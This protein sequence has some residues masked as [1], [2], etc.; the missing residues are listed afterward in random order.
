MVGFKPTYGEIGRGGV[1]PLAW[2]IDT[3]GVHARSVEDAALLIAVLAGHEPSDPTSPAHPS[4]VYFAEPEEA[5]RIHLGSF[6]TTSTNGPRR[7]PGTHRLIVVTLG[8]AGAQVE[9]VS[10]PADLILAH[11]AHRVVAFWSAPRSTRISM[12]STP[13]NGAEAEG[14]DRLGMVTPAVSYVQAQ[15]VRSRLVHQLRGLFEQ[16]DALIIPSRRAAR[17][18]I[19]QPQATRL[20]RSPGPSAVF[21]PSRYRQE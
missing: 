16:F 18:Q 7:G 14:I 10:P 6:A 2:S 5:S 4:S 3:I 21:P 13:N 8:K 12:P 15:R 9:E 20:S 11:S 1:M 19:C 17:Q